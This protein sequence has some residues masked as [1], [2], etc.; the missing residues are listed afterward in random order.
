MITNKGHWL[1]HDFNPDDYVGFVYKITSMV[2]GTFYIGKK[3]LHRTKKL[4]PLKGKKN[5]RHIKQQSDWETYTSSS[6]E[7]NNS[8]AT[9]GDNNHMF[10][11][12]ELHSTKLD[13]GVAE[14]C[15]IAQYMKDPKNINRFIGFKSVITK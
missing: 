2:D 11:I 5:K 7:M 12:L 10:E 1:T 4:P 9:H 8:I 13:L 15:C 3:L 14:F 6:K